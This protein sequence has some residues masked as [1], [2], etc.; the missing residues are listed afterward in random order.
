[1]AAVLVARGPAPDLEPSV[2]GLRQA[3]GRVVVVDNNDVEPTRPLSTTADQVIW[4]GNR[5]GLAGAYN[6][7]LASLRPGTSDGPDLVV[8]V[9]QD[10]DVSALARLLDDPEAAAL[11]LRGDVAAVSPAYRDRAT[12]LRGRYIE[13][14][15]WSLRHLPRQFAGPRVSPHSGSAVA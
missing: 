2:V 1:M 12:G 8:F 11:L 7:A 10:S 6:R 14:Q 15:R 5:G 9:D 4:N 3:V 13:L